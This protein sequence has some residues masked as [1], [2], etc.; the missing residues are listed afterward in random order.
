[1]SVSWFKQAKSKWHGVFKNE[2]N[3]SWTWSSPS[4]SILYM[5]KQ[6][7]SIILSWIRLQN[8]WASDPLAGSFRH[9]VEILASDQIFLHFYNDPHLRQWQW[10]SLGDRISSW[11]GCLLLGFS[12]PWNHSQEAERAWMMRRDEQMLE[13]E[14]PCYSSHR[15]VYWGKGCLVEKFVGDREPPKRKPH[16]YCSIASSAHMHLFHWNYWKPPFSLVDIKPETRLPA[17]C[18]SCYH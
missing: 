15:E 1:M 16:L 18:H 12:C 13:R 17:H 14:Q 9:T 4:N 3:P 2:Y 10:H 11:R 6:S 8:N 5:L 7:L